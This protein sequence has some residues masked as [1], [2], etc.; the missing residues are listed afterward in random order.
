MTS[1]LGQLKLF[2]NRESLPLWL[3]G[4]AAGLI[5][6]FA[7]SAL[8]AFATSLVARRQVPDVRTIWL[9]VGLSVLAPCTFFLSQVLIV[10][11]T[12]KITG[13]MLLKLSHSI[14]AAPL[15][16]LEKIGRDRIIAVITEDVYSVAR[17]LFAAP[18]IFLHSAILIGCF[19]YLAWMSIVAFLWVLA[20]LAIVVFAYAKAHAKAMDF[21]R[22]SMQQRDILRRH[23]GALTTGTKELKLNYRRRHEFL[24][25]HFYS[26]VQRYFKHN[27]SAIAIYTAVSSGY[28]FMFW[29]A[30]GL[31]A[32]V[33]FPWLK[34]PQA[35][36]VSFALVLIYMLREA[37]M[38][39]HTAPALA[40]VHV[41]IESV[42]RLGLKLSEHANAEGVLS[43][44]PSWKSIELR[45]VVLNYGS[46]DDS[47]SFRLGP[48]SLNLYP[49]EIVFVVGGNGCGKT[50][51][52]KVISGLYVP[53]E[54]EILLDGTK[55]DDSNRVSYS[56][57]F[58]AIFADFY[59]FDSLLGFDG[60]DRDSD[61]ERY[62][63][64]L[65][66]ESKV[67]FDDGRFST[68]DLS[69]GQRKRL[70]LLVTYLENRPVCILDEWAADQDSAFREYFYRELLPGMKLAGKCVIVIS[71]DDRYYNIADRVISLEYG[72]KRD[73]TLK[74]L[75]EANH[76][77][78]AAASSKLSPEYAI[79]Q[80]SHP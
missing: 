30:V 22:L 46:Q 13:E 57:L 44:I 55:I 61:A 25:G 54:G 6:G 41:R 50:T 9:L 79:E 1:M 39:A 23:I 14:L 56:E 38:L 21:M 48:I 27:L 5:S 62:L 64:K 28:E 10:H 3:V 73:E 63:A 49:G 11:I 75:P 31:I 36:A 47:S 34:L 51:L 67:K 20:F 72:L 15:L 19:V 69:Q 33:L 60:P 78:A 53:T 12:Q 18:D 43:P 42:Q 76:L 70:A 52:A 80:R 68:L 29:L 8:V 2:I 74:A 16:E 58:S 37:A 40:Q 45:D 35:T 66:L 59:L 26:A 7:G 77:E 71:H 4:I 32:F 17:G 65:R 24:D